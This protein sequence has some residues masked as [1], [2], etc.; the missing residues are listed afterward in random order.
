MD[1]MQQT[2]NSLLNISEKE[3][4]FRFGYKEI[5]NVLA[6][7]TLEQ[8][9][10]EMEKPFA[11]EKRLFTKY[12]EI[13][14]SVSEYKSQVTGIYTTYDAAIKALADKC[15]WYRPKGTGTIYEVSLIQTNNGY[16]EK[17]REVV[18]RKAQHMEL[19]CI[20]DIIVSKEFYER[21][22]M[23]TKNTKEQYEKYK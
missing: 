1:K 7:F 22:M 3:R 2:I 19:Y 23:L 11:L 18:Y 10:E 5:D 21:Y 20:D 8:I 14:N 9:V 15:D 4:F 16:L 12:Y 17:S 13:E 6:N